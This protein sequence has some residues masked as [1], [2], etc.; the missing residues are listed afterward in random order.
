LTP[1][2]QEE[3]HLSALA[4][5]SAQADLHNCGQRIAALEAELKASRE[6]HERLG[7]VVERAEIALSKARS[8]AKKRGKK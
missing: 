5:N 3:I 1:Q 7:R 8:A 6:E 2:Q 4:L